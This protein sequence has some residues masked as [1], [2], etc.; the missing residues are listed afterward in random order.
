M[1]LILISERTRY[2]YMTRAFLVSVMFSILNLVK[3]ETVSCVCLVKGE[4][5]RSSPFR[6]WLCANARLLLLL[7]IGLPFLCRLNRSLCRA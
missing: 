5:F 6:N 2:R 3:G 1:F 7:R 4:M